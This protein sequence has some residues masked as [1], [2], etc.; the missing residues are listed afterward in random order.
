MHVIIMR[1]GSEEQQ[2]SGL[3]Y[4][5]L[6]NTEYVRRIFNE[7]DKTI[8]SEVSYFIRLTFHHSVYEYSVL[9]YALIVN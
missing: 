4:V 6:I 3:L 9:R 8:L 1:R 7:L 2:F 5:V